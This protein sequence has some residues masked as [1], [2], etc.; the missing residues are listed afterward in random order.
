MGSFS[1]DFER[2]GEF[3][4]LQEPTWACCAR[5][6]SMSRREHYEQVKVVGA[7]RRAGVL[8]CSIPNGGWRTKETAAAMAAE[9]LAPGAPDLLVFDAPPPWRGIAIEM[10]V[11][12]GR[13]A[14]NQAEWH[15]AL[16]ARGWMVVVAWSAAEAVKALVDAGVMPIQ[17]RW[18]RI[19]DVRVG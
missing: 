12:G 10:K 14:P 18:A 5:I 8:F 16:R 1:F 15:E 19:E 7:L 2:L 11:A 9:G 4:G 13:V 17:S 6:Y 3:G